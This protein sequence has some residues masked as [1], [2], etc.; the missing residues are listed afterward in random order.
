[1]ILFLGAGASKPFE[2]P[3]TKGFIS[4]FETEVGESELY[5]DVKV[6]IGEEMFDLESLMTVLDDLSKPEPELLRHISP[7]TS[8]FLLRT[9]RE[10]GMVYYKKAGIG[11][12]AKQMLHRLKKVIRR[13]CLT[14]TR[15]R[16]EAIVK[17]YD[18][19]FDSADKLVGSH[20]L[21]GRPQ[22]S[23]PS[24]LSIFTTNYDTCVETYFNAKYVDF[25]NGIE[26]RWGYNIFNVNSYRTSAL[27]IVKLHGSID[28]FKKG[29]D[30]R[31]FQTVVEDFESLTT[32]LGEEYGE[33][34]MVWPIESSGAQHAIQSPHL[35]LYYLFRDRLGKELTK[36]KGGVWLIVGFSFRDLTVTS[37]MNEVA[38]QIE[39]AVHLNVILID[40]EATY[41]K[42][43]IRSD[44]FATLA[45][46]ITPLDDLFGSPNL[47]TRLATMS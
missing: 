27:E 16:R 33:E 9:L 42:E 46:L 15:E 34:F 22:R 4:L 45:D 31:H 12:D 17:T 37:I 1:M 19:F 47:L 44:G 10:S 20:T 3:T 39:P 21:S 36:E 13:A 14:A 28:L 35:D 2:I 38:R 32:H 26:T 43:K 25:A 24:Q 7:Y 23:Y 11:E 30:I 6:G 8:R 40:T 18:A 29:D 41:I 5:N